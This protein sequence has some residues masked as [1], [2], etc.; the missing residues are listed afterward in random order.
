MG[1]SILEQLKK[2]LFGV[3]FLL[4]SCGMPSEAT[5]E[6]AQPILDISPTTLVSIVGTT[7]NT[8]VPSAF[9]GGI[10]GFT[11]TGS[12]T[13]SIGGTRYLYT[14]IYGATSPSVGTQGAIGKIRLSDFTFQGIVGGVQSVLPITTKGCYSGVKIDSNGDAY[15]LCNDIADSYLRVH[16]VNLITEAYVST[17]KLPITFSHSFAIDVP[18]NY[19]YVQQADFFAANVTVKIDLLT[20]LVSLVSPANGCQTLV[21]DQPNQII[22]CGLDT[23]GTSGSGFVKIT[24]LN[25]MKVSVT[26][27]DG[28]A[29]RCVD[30]ALDS[31]HGY[32]YCANEPDRSIGQGKNDRI[33]RAPISLLSISSIKSSFGGTASYSLTVSPIRGYLYVIWDGDTNGV[34]MPTNQAVEVIKLSTFSSVGFLVNPDVIGNTTSGVY[35]DDTD[36][37]LYTTNRQSPAVFTKYSLQ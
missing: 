8:Y 32:V 27:N 36:G 1:K 25:T 13:F 26:I 11:S 16:K 9:P 4:I 10:A 3:L 7:T 29:G 24:N 31:V 22:Y 6:N 30:I 20:F 12:S 33:M 18:N 34:K 2:A 21:L 5:V 15:I 35:L 37:F 19:L 28:Q 23:N 14:S 17:L